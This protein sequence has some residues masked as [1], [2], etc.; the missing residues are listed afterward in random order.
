[1]AGCVA[2]QR[3]EAGLRDLCSHESQRS[4]ASGGSVGNGF[5]E[6]DVTFTAGGKGYCKGFVDSSV[7]SGSNERISCEAE[8]AASCSE[9]TF[10]EV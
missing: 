5:V 4:A 3:V 8:S 2:V 1:M 6:Q 9:E 10:L 7:V